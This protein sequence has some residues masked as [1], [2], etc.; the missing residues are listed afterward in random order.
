[1]QQ[2]TIT[3]VDKLSVANLSFYKKEAL[4]EKVDQIIRG[5]NLD[6]ALS[7]GNLYKSSVLIQFRNASGEAIETEAT[8]WAVTEKY[9]MIKGGT[10]IPIKSIFNVVT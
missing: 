8:V 6:R 9:I 5:Y 3:K 4:S 1:M 7:L 10:V 2:K